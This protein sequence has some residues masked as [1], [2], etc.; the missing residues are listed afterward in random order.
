MALVLPP[1]LERL[2]AERKALNESPDPSEFCR[3]ANELRDPKDDPASDEPKDSCIKLFAEP[4]EFRDW[5]EAE[6]LVRL[7]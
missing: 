5:A 7:C 2:L 4:P 1:K 3:D 6:A